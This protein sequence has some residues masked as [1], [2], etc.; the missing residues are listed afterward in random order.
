MNHEK[1]ILDHIPYLQP[2]YRGPFE[3]VFELNSSLETFIIDV[4]WEGNDFVISDASLVNCTI[5][6]ANFVQRVECEVL[7][8]QTVVRLYL[9]K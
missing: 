8:S 2:S 7:T 3:I 1:Y 4:I 9:Y 6:A 5:S